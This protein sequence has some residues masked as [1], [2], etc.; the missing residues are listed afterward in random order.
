M[1]EPGKP[2]TGPVAKTPGWLLGIWKVDTDDT[3]Q[4]LTLQIH[5]TAVANRFGLEPKPVAAGSGQCLPRDIQ[6][7][8]QGCGNRNVTRG[9]GRVHSARCWWRRKDRA[10]LILPGGLQRGCVQV[11]GDRSLQGP[12]SHTSCQ[13][14]QDWDSAEQRLPWHSV[15]LQGEQP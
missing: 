4:L 15:L 6:R 1:G 12:C 5:D 13:G 7:C 11:K 9:H 14:A 2:A 3:L 8:P 10:A